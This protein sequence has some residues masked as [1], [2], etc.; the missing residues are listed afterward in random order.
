MSRAVCLNCMD[1]RIQLPVIEWIRNHLDIECVD[2][3][4][5]AGMD[6]YLA[7]PDNPAEHVLKKTRISIDVNQSIAIYVVGHFDCRGN[8]ADDETHQRQIREAVVRISRDF[9]GIPVAGLWVDSE[10]AVHKITE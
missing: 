1:G 10:W 5:E 4:T 6:G 3:V 8:R 2:M 9:P 7:N